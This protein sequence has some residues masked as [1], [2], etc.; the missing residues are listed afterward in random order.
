MWKQKGLLREPKSY[1]QEA[2]A[3]ASKEYIESLRCYSAG[4]KPRDVAIF[5]Q[6]HNEYPIVTF[7]SIKKYVQVYRL[8]F[9][10]RLETVRSP[11]A[12]RR[13]AKST[14]VKH[15]LN[16]RIYTR[17][18][19]EAFWKQNGLLRLPKSHG[20]EALAIASKEYIENL[21]C[22]AEVRRL[23]VKGERPRDVAIFI[24]RHNEYPIV[25]F[26]SIKKYAQVYARF[27]IPPLETVR[28]LA[29][30]P[31]RAKSTIVTCRL[32]EVP[33]SLEEIEEMEKLIQTQTER[34]KDQ[35]EKEKSLGVPLPGLHR[36]ILTLAKFLAKLFDLKVTLGLYTRE[37]EKRTSP[38]QI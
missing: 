8:F 1:R 9:I 19:K 34:V 38:N 27:F 37:P 12:E 26:N 13:R 16:S 32:A 33:Q 7:N 10:P 24:Q 35:I 22:Y 17:S 3:L 11:A 6:R 14:I 4:K 18:Q 15:R 36:E 2:L 23:L 30:E 20:Q 5:I 21:R 29:A 28:S 25:T 31:R